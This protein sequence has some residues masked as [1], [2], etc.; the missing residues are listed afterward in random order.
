MASR[1]EEEISELQE[2]DRDQFS[3]QLASVGMLGRIAAEHCIPLLTRYTQS[4]DTPWTNTVY[5]QSP[6][7]HLK[8]LR[9]LNTPSPCPSTR[10]KWTETHSR[11]RSLACTFGAQAPQHRWQ[12]DYGKHGMRSDGTRIS[13][14]LE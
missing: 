6:G 3:D 11:L 2:D 13:N 10:N 4:K 1:E 9:T 12:R 5:S 14:I 8:C 7:E